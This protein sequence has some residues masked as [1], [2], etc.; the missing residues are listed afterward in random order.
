MKKSYITKNK[1]IK[2]KK[3]VG[4]MTFWHIAGVHAT[5]FFKRSSVQLTKSC[6]RVVTLSLIVAINWLGVVGVGDTFAYFSDTASST[7][8]VFTAGNFSISL[9]SSFF[10]DTIRVH[11]AADTTHIVG[12][13]PNVGS[14]PGQYT[15]F[16]EMTGGDS[17]FCE[18]IGM[19]TKLNGFKE[20]EGGISLLNTAT[21]TNFGTWEFT[22][23]IVSGS[24]VG[25]NDTC[26][27]DIVFLAWQENIPLQS[28]G[29]TDEKRLSL[30]FMAGMV[31]LNEVYPNEDSTLV[32]PFEREWIELFNNGN[33]PVDIEGWK[34]SEITGGNEIKHVISSSNTCASGSKVGFARPYNNTGTVISP[35]AR[36]VIEFCAH[37][38]LGNMGD[39][40]TLY[41]NEDKVLDFVTYEKLVSK[42]QSIARG[43]TVIGQ[44]DG[45]GLWF[46]PIPTPGMPNIVSSD[47][48]IVK[49]MHPEEAEAQAR[50]EFDFEVYQEKINARSRAIKEKEYFTEQ[51]GELVLMQNNMQKTTTSQMD[52]VTEQEN[53]KENIQEKKKDDPEDEQ[54]GGASSGVSSVE[55]VNN[56]ENN[57]NDETKASTGDGIRDEVK[58]QKSTDETQVDTVEDEQI[59]EGR[60]SSLEINARKEDIEPQSGSNESTF[61]SQ[62]QLDNTSDKKESKE[63]EK[64]DKPEV[65]E[66]TPEEIPVNDDAPVEAIT[67][68]ESAKTEGIITIEAP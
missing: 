21:T 3:I 54:A 64:S 47:D 37:N 48:P 43:S 29:F 68:T 31:V 62:L 58:Q 1:K 67:T 65:I 19:V 17:D 18:A 11:T 20:Y 66:K 26:E 49:E 16:S 44:G 27:I 57:K 40:I 8:N 7:Q 61:E 15:L 4:M 45:I 23:D 5:L 53:I 14:L 51:S 6:V 59:Q 2:T 60:D 34:V 12:V 9:T 63:E 38:R 56:E 36:K 35:G 42:G 39:T 46:D 52:T 33:I 30:S 10:S 13:Q 32:A 22:F 24:A 25:H 28:A 41:D 55:K 50:G